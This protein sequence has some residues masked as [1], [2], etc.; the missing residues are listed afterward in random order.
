MS[1][2]NLIDA[3]SNLVDLIVKDIVK[4]LNTAWHKELFNSLPVLSNF[5][6]NQ[7]ISEIKKIAGVLG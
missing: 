3:I 2:R 6:L 5:E 7:K 1:K 4:T